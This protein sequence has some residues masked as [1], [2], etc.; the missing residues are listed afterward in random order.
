LYIQNINPEEYKYKRQYPLYKTVRIKA[1]NLVRIQA[2]V[3]KYKM[4]IDDIITEI[5]QKLEYYENKGYEVKED[6]RSW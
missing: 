4:T 6:Q 3:T 2:R 1:S 5:L